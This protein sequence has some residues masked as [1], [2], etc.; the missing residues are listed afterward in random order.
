[1]RFDIDDFEVKPFQKED[2]ELLWYLFQECSDFFLLVDKRLPR[3]S[4][5]SGFL[6]HTPENKDISDKTILGVYKN[7]TLYGVIDLIKDYPSNGVWFFSLLLLSPKIRKQGLGEKIY[8]NL[9]SVLVKKG[10]TRVMISVAKQN[11]YAKAFWTKLGFNH[12]YSKT[13][14]EGQVETIFDYMEDDLNL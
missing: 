9:K 10:A 13:E 1:M 5:V 3:K 11:I 7:N 14:V 12:K 4:D 2:S 6:I 8:T